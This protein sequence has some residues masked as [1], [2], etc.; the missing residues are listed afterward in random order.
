MK[1]RYAAGPDDRRAVRD[2]VRSTGF[3]STEE[4]AIAVELVEERLAR[5]EASGYEFVFAELAPF[6]G[7]G[8]VPHST[9]LGAGREDASPY[10][11]KNA[12]GTKAPAIVG[13]ACYGPIAGT[14]DSFDLYWIAVHAEHRGNGLGKRLLQAT[15][16]AV[17]AAGGDRLYAET[18]SRAQYKPTHRFY[19]ACGFKCEALLKDFYAPGDDKLIYRLDVTGDLEGPGHRTMR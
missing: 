14:R 13:Y 10:A 3:F 18:S 19:E 12:A 1:L 17:R 16:E 5:G 9:D 6:R 15:V 8:V 2:I 11:G 7:K 4:E